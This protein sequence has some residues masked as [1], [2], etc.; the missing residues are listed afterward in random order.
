MAWT[1]NIYCL[2]LPKDTKI[3]KIV[4]DN[5]GHIGPYK[6]AV[7][8]AVSLG[9]PVLAPLK[10]EIATVVDKYSE[11]GASL[12]FADKVNYIQIRHSSGETS[13]LMHLAKGSALVK[14]GDKIITGQE[15]AKT[16]ESGYMTAPHLHWFV[17]KL[18]KS[19]SGFE[20]LKIK[21]D[22]KTDKTKIY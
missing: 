10:G 9:I 12:E 13:D 7:D 15:I 18:T 5:P 21:L 4:T 3:K 6:G 19:K 11:Y 1:K 8:F 14:V 17:F 20:G 16:G 22:N 2:P